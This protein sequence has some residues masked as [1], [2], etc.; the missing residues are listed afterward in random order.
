[1]RETHGLAAPALLG[2]AIYFFNPTVAAHQDM[3]SLVAAGSVH[4]AEKPFVD[5]SFTTGGI[6]V[7]GRARV[8]FA[9]GSG[10]GEKL[11]IND[12]NPDESRVNRADK[13]GRLVSVLPK[14]PPK[15]FNAGSV[16][17][18]SS[19]LLQPVEA[20]QVKMAFVPSKSRR[21]EIDIALAFH[22]A[23]PPKPAPAMPVQLAKLINNG[24]PDI[25]ATGYAPVE[26]DYTKVSPFASIL[27]DGSGGRFTPPLK[28]GDHSWAAAP[29]PAQV[30][31]AKE[32]KCLAE[33]IYFEARGESI[34]GQAAVA[35]V[36]LNRVRNPAFPKTVC[37]VVYQNDNWRNRCQ[38][39][40]ACDG[41]R[42]RVTEP[43]HWSTAQE[44][45]KA[46]SSGQIWLPE[47]GSATH[48]H[49]AY[50][51]PRWASAME[52]VKKIGLHIFYR[53]QGGGWS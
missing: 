10:Q 12:P 47:V 44:V 26:P 20:R 42:Q 29:L 27:R 53:T 2:A 33:G 49:A 52:R 16:L 24:N 18:R 40:F 17:Q 36:I 37:G 41:R 6:D 38:F 22:K 31:T 7:A 45:A 34:K 8:A 13:G 14:A 46:V 15:S 4:R 5:P 11:G 9:S 19:M 3:A 39:S 35:Q 43:E 25:L 28:P 1:M 23:A 51:K 30:F 21:K 48:Y 32:Q 50:V